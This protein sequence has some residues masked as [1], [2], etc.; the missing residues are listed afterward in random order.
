M[1]F[2]KSKTKEMYDNDQD[3][4]RIVTETITRATKIV[5]SS[6]GPGGK[7]TLLERA[8]QAPIA[9]KDGITI[10]KHLGF[11]SASHNS[12][13]DML[14]ETSAN[15]AAVA[16][17]GT[18]SALILA[19]AIYRYGK[20]FVNNNPKYNPQRFMRELKSCYENEIVSFLT[21]ISVPVKTKDDMRN[22]AL[23][24]SN[25]DIE[26][27]DAV[28]ESIIA[29]GEDGHVLIQ[30]DQNANFRVETIDGYVVTSGLKDMSAIGS[31]FINDRAGQQVKM[32]AGLTVMFDG[33]LNDL[34]LLGRIQ[35]AMETNPELFGKPIIIFAYQFSDPVIEKCLK[36]SRSG[37]TVLPVKV[38]RSGLPNSGQI[39][40]QDMAA[41]TDGSVLDPMSAPTFEAQHFGTFTTAKANT[42]ETFIQAEGD[43]E[44]IDARVEEL[45]AIMESSKSEHDKS[46]LRAHIGKLTGGI[47]TIYVGGLTD[48]EIRERKDRVQDAVEAVRSAIAEGIVCGGGVTHKMLVD[49]L[50]TNPNRKPSWIVME[51]ALAMPFFYIMSNCGEG[52][53]INEVWP[54][55]SNQTVFDADT[56]TMV[57]PWE[58]GIIEGSR[59]HK[60]SIGNALS[61]AS[62]LVT[63]GGI[64]V[65]PRDSNM[66]AQ[67]E[68]SRMAFKDAL[69]TQTG[70]E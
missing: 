26:I 12:V 62:L 41:Y 24:S 52:D 40:L 44:K 21:Q 1:I 43:T 9:S 25:G 70:E 63:L 59:V 3:I 30:E 4:E 5:A 47:S 49:F 55:L 7:V 50:T 28:V 11:S 17:D 61:I 46:H 39:F 38:P 14:K 56:H 64:V 69:A 37:V 15:C 16:G 13:L 35:D 48:S 8:E 42:Y 18:T 6:C 53:L 2:V 19:E 33:S 57:N 29:A 45:K 22:V 51:Q 20:I 67:I 23:I 10:L 54:Q 31:A 32:D 66:E 34:V 60:S 27:A 58:Q 65:A 36:T 68:M